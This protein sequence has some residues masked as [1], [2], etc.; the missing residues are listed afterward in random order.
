MAR[1]KIPPMPIE[2]LID[3]PR[4][5]LL[6]VA[7]FGMLTKVLMR[8]WAGECKRRHGS[9]AELFA[10]SEAHRATFSSHKQELQAILADL[11]PLY[12][13]KW[14]VR[15]Q[16]N[17][18]VRLLLARASAAKARRRL[19][20]KLA[21]PETAVAAESA[22]LSQSV[23]PARRQGRVAASPAQQGGGFRD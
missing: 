10:W 20:K 15:L 2:E 13:H 16:K 1:R 9:P 18:G 7:A 3:H 21:S 4:V 14:A 22:R 11:Y 6:P 8:F 12:E 23:S 17:E 5:I 19:E